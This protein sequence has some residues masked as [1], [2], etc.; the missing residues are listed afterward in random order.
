[1]SSLHAA[2]ASA[3]VSDSTDWLSTP[4]APLAPL[5]SALRCQVCKD[6]FNTPMMTSCSHTFCS[7]CIRR[8]LSQEGRCPACRTADQ[9]L[10]LRRNWV[11]EELVSGFVE[12]R[13]GLLNFARK[14][15]EADTENQE[16]G[17]GPR[18]KKRRKVE[19]PQSQQNVAGSERRSTRS[20][21]RK[22]AVQ[23]SQESAATQTIAD[24]DDAGSEYEEQDDKHVMVQATDQKYAQAGPNDGLVACPGCGKRM[25][26]EV[27]FTH[28]DHCTSGGGNEVPDT[29]PVT[30][31]LHRPPPNQQPRAST[32]YTP[33]DMLSSDKPRERLPT[34]AYSMLNDTALRKKLQALG[35]S[36]QGPKLL[37]QKR[38]TE[39]V[40]LWNANCDSRN[41]M[42]KRDLLGELDVW[43]RTQGRQILQGM[44]ASA[45][46]G[47]GTGVM[48]KD[49]DGESWMKGN[50]SDF[51]EL[52][53]RARQKRATAAPVDDKKSKAK[54]ESGSGTSAQEILRGTSA[55]VNGNGASS[56]MTLQV[57]PDPQT[58]AT[59]S[60]FFESAVD[61]VAELD[62]KDEVRS[63]RPVP[64]SSPLGAVVDLTSTAEPPTERDQSQSQSSHLNSVFA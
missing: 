48:A 2:S 1:M 29:A 12:E 60:P 56:Q 21:S 24:S 34:L 61:S 16:E 20:Q 42:T 64:S 51:E 14:C 62:R 39:W 59:K 18:P 57:G 54:M 10:K 36:S 5:E 35:I 9:E 55:S 17:E 15:A 58:S 43:E 38:H 32:A 46:G 41:P 49:F 44:S 53:R 31:G 40:N 6:F 33:L 3:S 30:N 26:E 4:L 23:T 28:L 50:K 19:A 47:Q 27:V 45:G 63:K 37:L 8:Y 25:K 11:V 13:D 7:L 22:D 52:V